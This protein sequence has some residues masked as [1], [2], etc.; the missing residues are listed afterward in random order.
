MKPQS[1]M[2]PLRLAG[3][4]PNVPTGCRK[5]KAQLPNTSHGKP[6]CR[7]VGVSSSRPAQPLRLTVGARK[8]WTRAWIPDLQ[9]KKQR[10]GIKRRVQET[11]ICCRPQAG[12]DSVL[13]WLESL[14]RCMLWPARSR[15]ACRTAVAGQ[16]GRNPSSPV[17]LKDRVQK[18]VRKRAKLPK[19]PNRHPQSMGE[20]AR[21]RGRRTARRWWRVI[22][23]VQAPHQ[24]LCP[25]RRR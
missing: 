14:V 23:A 9:Q 1:W 22:L 11:W 20:R 2:S 17:L 7:G 16:L 10:W 5:R 4:P 3:H 18:L 24:K 19:T 25:R 21:L 6:R 8:N 12:F 13:A 15:S